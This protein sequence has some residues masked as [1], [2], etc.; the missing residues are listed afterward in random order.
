MPKVLPLTSDQISK[1]NP[2]I[3]RTVQTLRSWGF[4]T[5]DSGDGETHDYECDMPVPYVH[6]KCP[7]PLTLVGEAMRLHERL[8]LAGIDFS[9]PPNPQFDPEGFER[10]PSIE[11]SYSPVDGHAFITLTNV[12]I[13]ESK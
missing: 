6:I 9:S 2:G 3:R 8:K 1:V 10:H 4:E 7:H 5:C 12:V 11:A 13:P